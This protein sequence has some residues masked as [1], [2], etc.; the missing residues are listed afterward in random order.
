MKRPLLIL[1]CSATKRTG[2][3][4]MSAYEL[5]DGPA[6]RVLRA[7][8]W[9]HASE[10][11]DCRLVILSAE[12]GLLSP[13]SRVWDYDRR[14]DEARA[15]ELS[16]MDVQVVRSALFVTVPWS[17]HRDSFEH[18][19]ASEVFAWGGLLYRRV[20]EKWEEAGVFD[21]VPGGVTYSHGG[22]GVQLGQLKRW[23]C[24]RKA[25]P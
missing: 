21:A 12:H 7:S 3:G 17:R 9:P 11:P 1:A 25:T 6:F 14:M 20:I 16:A 4:P 5:Y 2:H 23:L 18:L 8:G 24:A 15:G 10:G 13:W 19:P 22:I